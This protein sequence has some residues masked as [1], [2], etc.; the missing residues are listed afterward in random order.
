MKKQILT[1]I[2]VAAT[3]MAQAQTKTVKANG[4]FEIGKITNNYLLVVQNAGKQLLAIEQPKSG[5]NIPIDSLK[6]FVK[7]SQI[8]WIND[9]TAIIHKP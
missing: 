8:R 7:K 3:Y 6:I 1:A 9:S 4:N 2:I 5:W